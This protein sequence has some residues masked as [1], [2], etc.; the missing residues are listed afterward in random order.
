LAEAVVFEVAPFAPA[1]E[2]FRVV[3]DV[4]A[5]GAAVDVGALVS[6]VV[7]EVLVDIDIFLCSVSEKIQS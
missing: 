2:V 4:V 3:L 7:D 6:R 1:S 5:G